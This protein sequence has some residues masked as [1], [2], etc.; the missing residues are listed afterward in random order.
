MQGSEA[1]GTSVSTQ[2][3][4]THRRVLC[5][6]E[7]G[8]HDMIVLVTGSMTVAAVLSRHR[9]V[10]TC[11]GSPPPIRSL[12]SCGYSRGWV[13]NMVSLLTCGFAWLLPQH[14]WVAGSWL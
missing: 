2:T 3:V 10:S 13:V 5:L 7:Q 11:K 6:S 9:N 8:L 1:C 14:T 12:Q 4:C